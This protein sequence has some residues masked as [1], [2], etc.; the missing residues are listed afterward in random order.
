MKT[1][2]YLSLI[3][4]FF[5]GKNV[6][7]QEDYKVEYLFDIENISISGFAGCIVE[8][9]SIN[10]DFAAATGGGGAV[11][12]N[13]KVFF[14][15]AGSGIATNHS[16][17]DIYPKN[18]NPATDNPITDLQ[19]SF[20]YGGAWIGYINQSHKLI[21]WGVNTIIGGGGISIYEKEFNVDYN[22]YHRDNVFVLLPRIEAE[23]NMASWFKIR[24]GIGYR[25][26]YGID[27]DTYFNENGEQV[28]YF[29]T[30]DFNTPTINISF[31]F[32][33]FWLK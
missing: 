13:Q 7:S 2:I 19:L 22:S 6:Y 11:L 24:G 30:S 5:L 33:A 20:G 27:N 15:G 12:I 23:V 25:F 28:K 3:L 10:N 4:I 8:F 14:G 1:T 21:H 18:Y 31:M 26:V 9:T 17:P 29:K 32:G 16:W